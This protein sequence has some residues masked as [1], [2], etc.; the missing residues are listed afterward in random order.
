MLYLVVSETS[1]KRFLSQS[2]ARK[3][4][5]D[6][7]FS[8]IQSDL[9]NQNPKPALATDAD[10]DTTSSGVG[11]AGQGKIIIAELP[12]DRDLS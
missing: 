1:V 3:A 7:R 11:V 10:S 8:L 6:C 2:L 4:G 9:P 12:S 5:C